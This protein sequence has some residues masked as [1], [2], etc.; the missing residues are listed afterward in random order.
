MDVDRKRTEEEKIIFKTNVLVP[1][2]E[3]AKVARYVVR[4]QLTSYLHRHVANAPSDSR[5]TAVETPQTIGSY[6]LNTENVLL[7]NETKKRRQSS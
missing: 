4:R 7:T 6:S 5:Q 2:N 3:G 1:K